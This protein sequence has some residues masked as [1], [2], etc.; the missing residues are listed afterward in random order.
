MPVE[1]LELLV[2]VPVA[3]LAELLVVAPLLL[4]VLSMPLVVV[5][6]LLVVLAGID[7]VEVA[8]VVPVELSLVMIPP[9]P[10]TTKEANAM[11]KM[12]MTAATGTD[13]PRQQ[14][15]TDAVRMTASFSP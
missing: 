12:T 14:A 4:V 7:V 5:A 3:L 1:L 11:T 9:L 15:E 2:V 10:K 8:L 6:T 13:T